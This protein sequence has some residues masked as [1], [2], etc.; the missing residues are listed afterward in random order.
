MIIDSF[1]NRPIYKVHYSK[2][3]ELASILIPK[4]EEHIRPEYNFFEKMKGI[5]C[6]VKNYK[7]PIESK[8]PKQVPWL[9]YLNDL[10]KFVE[11]HSRLYVNDS[12]IIP[13]I[14]GIWI[15]YYPHNTYFDYHQHTAVQAVAVL[16]LQKKENAG[17]MWI[18]ESEL[19]SEEYEIV[20]EEGDLLIF[21]GF[22]PH[23]TTPNLSNNIRV[24]ITFDLM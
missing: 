11:T 20:G 19:D 18:K 10:T 12:S 13:E 24:A 5:C 2:T 6:L 23:K 21:P 3:Q 9:E 8:L 17:N 16:Y 1:P 14:E 7:Y 4:I 22:L 15:S